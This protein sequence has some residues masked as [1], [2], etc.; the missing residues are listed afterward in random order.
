[1]AVTRGE[2]DREQHRRPPSKIGGLEA[3]SRSRGVPPLFSRRSNVQSSARN[4]RC[5]ELIN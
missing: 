3:S 5:G 1:M 2:V 4:S